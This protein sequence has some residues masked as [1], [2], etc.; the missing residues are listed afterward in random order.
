LADGSE[1]YCSVPPV[2]VQIGRSSSGRRVA[3]VHAQ[4][5]RT[6]FVKQVFSAYTKPL[7][8]WKQDARDVRLEV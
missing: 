6:L 2:G 4:I 8:E 1:S 3:T 5:A 7:G